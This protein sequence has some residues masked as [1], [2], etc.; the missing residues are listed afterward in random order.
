MYFLQERYKRLLALQHAVCSI[1]WLNRTQNVD[2]ITRL[3]HENKNRNL[4]RRQKLQYKTR[5]KSIVPWRTMHTGRMSDHSTNLPRRVLIT[6]SIITVRSRLFP[7]N[8]ASDCLRFL[9]KF[10]LT[11]TLPSRKTD[12]I[13]LT[14]FYLT[15][16]W[17]HGGAE[18]AVLLVSRSLKGL[19]RWLIF[20][21]VFSV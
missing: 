3:T 16:H 8:S 19:L 6:M 11:N 14:N 10:T 9:T 15:I 20:L 13:P 12:T 17:H 1:P 7:A 21:R 18:N 5:N 4:K 2:L